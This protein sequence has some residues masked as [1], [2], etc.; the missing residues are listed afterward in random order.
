MTTDRFIDGLRATQGIHERFGTLKRSTADVPAIRVKF[1]DQDPDDL[2]KRFR[3]F[4]ADHDIGKCL[5]E[6]VLL[7]G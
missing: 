3:S 1:L 7:L 6:S 2:A 5:C 4:K